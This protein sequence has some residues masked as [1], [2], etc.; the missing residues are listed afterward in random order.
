MP[1]RAAFWSRNLD[2]LA[3]LTR[4]YSLSFATDME[5]A[6]PWMKIAKTLARSLGVPFASAKSPSPP[7]RA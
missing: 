1:P 6:H 2:A 4:Y 3:G 7:P 5:N